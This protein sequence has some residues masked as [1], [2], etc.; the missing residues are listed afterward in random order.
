M[1]L[2]VSNK[3]AEHHLWSPGPSLQ[4]A[5][6]WWISALFLHPC[7]KSFSYLARPQFERNEPSHFQ[8]EKK[9]KR[10]KVAHSKLQANTH[11]YE[12]NGHH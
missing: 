12:Y 11:H 4:G 10:F 2:T 3:P 8:V 9:K 7:P 6:R 5:P 1:V